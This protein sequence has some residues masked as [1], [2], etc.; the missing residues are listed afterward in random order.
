[1]KRGLILLSAAMWGVALATSP[2]QAHPHEN[3][4]WDSVAVRARVLGSHPESMGAQ[5]VPLPNGT[6]AQLSSI[7]CTLVPVTAGLLMQNE[8]GGALGVGG[9]FLGPSVGYFVGGH[10]VRGVQGALARAGL[11]A[12]GVGFLGVGFTQGFVEGN[13]D[14]A[15][16]AV[17]ASAVTGVCVLVSAVYDMVTVPDTVE[18]HAAV[19][20]RLRLHS[21]WAPGSGAPALALSMGF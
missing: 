10:P 16:V 14:A 19:H 12:L 17:V 5:G 1:M 13:E 2:L 11:T 8:V 9:V 18:R 20:A 6:A 21:M 4:D 3:A 7:V 15:T